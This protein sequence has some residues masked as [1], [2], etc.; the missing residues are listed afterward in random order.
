MGGKFKLGP[1]YQTIKA[2]PQLQGVKLEGGEHPGMMMDAARI[3]VSQMTDVDENF[4]IQ[5]NVRTDEVADFGA[6]EVFDQMFGGKRPKQKVVPTSAI[7]LKADKVRMHS[8][9]DIKIVTGGQSEMYNSLGNR[10]KRNNGIH[11]IAENGRDKNNKDLPQHPMVLGNNL[12]KVLEFYGLLIEDAVQCMDAMANTQMAFN[13]IIASNF[14]L[15]PIPS[16]TTVP[17]PFKQL[18][19]I[20]TQLELLIKTRFGALF[21]LWN[22]FGGK[23]NYLKDSATNENYILSRYNTVN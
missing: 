13:Q 5:Q 16:A 14:D 22:N 9:Q 20:V 10:I 4:G 21:Q 18:A 17:N 19:G 23:S 1:I 11:L 7:M 15:L 2:P 6:F 8:R 3:Y 12:V